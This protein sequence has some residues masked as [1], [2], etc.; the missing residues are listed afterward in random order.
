MVQVGG[1]VGSVSDG[2][3]DLEVAV[4]AVPLV[5]GL[6]DAGRP[7]DATNDR[8]IARGQP[9]Q[10]VAPGLPEPVVQVVAQHDDGFD[11]A[12][13][14]VPVVALDQAHVEPLPHHRHS[15]PQPRADNDL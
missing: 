2:D 7:R 8:V 12:M 11:V 3:D 14:P 1:A 13:R 15:G 6:D 9:G 4:P 5:V 10:A